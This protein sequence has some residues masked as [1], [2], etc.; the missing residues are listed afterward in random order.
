M[1]V[2]TRVLRAGSPRWLALATLCPCLFFAATATASALELTFP[3]DGDV[4]TR[5]DGVETAEGLALSVRGTAP[6]GAAVRVNG[7]AAA[8]DG[9]AFSCTVPV[10]AR[11]AR[12][13]AESDGARAEAGLEGSRGDIGPRG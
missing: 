6:A 7:V 10:T 4:V 2:M 9:E 12:I 11:R 3:R 5:Q 8:R 1:V 13:I